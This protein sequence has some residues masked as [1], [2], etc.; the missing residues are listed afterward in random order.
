[1][2]SKSLLIKLK[3]AGI[4]DFSSFNF[5]SG[6]K[7]NIPTEGTDLARE[8]IFQIDNEFFDYASLCEMKNGKIKLLFFKYNPDYKILINKVYEVLGS[9]HSES[10]R[11]QFDQKDIAKIENWKHEYPDSKNSVLREWKDEESGY[12]IRIG[13]N[14]LEQSFN[15][16]ETSLLLKISQ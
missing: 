12:F 9:D 3:T 11:A 13:F 2:E 6:E 10:K 16:Q 15:K 8:S 5:E 1:M 4:L 7:V 14:N